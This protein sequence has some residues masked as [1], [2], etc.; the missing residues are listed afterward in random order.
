MILII[1]IYHCEALNVTLSQ[2]EILKV[3]SWQL[4]HSHGK[5]KT[6]RPSWV[7]HFFS[8]ICW[9]SNMLAGKPW[10]PP[11]ETPPS[12]HTG[13]RQPT[14]LLRLCFSNRPVGL[15]NQLS[16]PPPPQDCRHL[17]HTMGGSPGLRP[18][19]TTMPVWF[20]TSRCDIIKLRGPA[21]VMLYEG[22]QTYTNT[23]LHTTHWHN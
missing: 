22:S 17:F 7:W 20:F 8:C 19:S 6:E 10:H 4:R 16:L 18:P 23:H 2:C 14:A 21:G 9:H 5:L 11:T 15:A 13:Y 1:E 3:E 12:T